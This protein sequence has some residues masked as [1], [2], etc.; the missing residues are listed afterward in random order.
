MSSFPMHRP[1][2]GARILAGMSALLFLVI[3]SV[4]SF[5]GTAAGGH[6][7][8]RVVTDASGSRL[9][10]AGQDFLVRGMNWDYVPIGQNYAYDLF[11]QPDDIVSRDRI[12]Q[13][14]L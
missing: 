3:A 13:D 4:A 1:Q 8:V 9:Q 11:Q 7:T 6:E 14:G 5:A 10:V 2:C 12:I